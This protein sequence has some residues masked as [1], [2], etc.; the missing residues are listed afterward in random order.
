MKKAI[1]AYDMLC[2]STSMAFLYDEVDMSSSYER[3]CWGLGESAGSD[4]VFHSFWAYISEQYKEW[5]DS[6]YEIKDLKEEGMAKKL[7]ESERA[8]ISI[9][10]LLNSMVSIDS[11]ELSDMRQLSI[12]MGE[13][14]FQIEHTEIGTSLNKA[15]FNYAGDVCAKNLECEPFRKM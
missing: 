3:L 14:P 4:V 15:F 9:D 2:R 10:Q 12:D 8:A 5:V 11:F 13:V 7:Y 6:E 1:I